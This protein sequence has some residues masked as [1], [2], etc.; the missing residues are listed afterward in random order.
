MRSEL[1]HW[2]QDGRKRPRTDRVE[3]RVVRSERL[4]S[5]SCVEAGKADNARGGPTN[6]QQKEMRLPGG[7]GEGTATGGT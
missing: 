7:K 4:V 2:A 6:L 3:R 5:P 1:S